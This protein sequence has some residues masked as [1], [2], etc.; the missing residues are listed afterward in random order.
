MK[1]V[2]RSL[3]VLEYI[4]DTQP[5]GVSEIARE[6]DE[7]KSSVQRALDTLA[8]GHWI[9]R[10]ETNPSLW[11]VAVRTAMLGRNFT[12]K[13]D[14][15]TIA[16]SYMET[17][18]QETGETIHLAVPREAS[19]ILIE[20]LESP[21]RLRYVEPLGGAASMF[22]TATGKSVLAHLPETR[23]DELISAHLAAIEET[24]ETRESLLTELAR[25][26]ELG[27][28][29]TSAW[30]SEVYATAAVITG[31][32]G[33]PVAALS[34]SVPTARIT[35][36]IKPLHAELVAAAARSI[37]KRFQGPTNP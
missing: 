19:V 31:E 17:L 9:A 16:L 30:R 1:S 21:H 33:E 37:S 8:K 18:R 10:D 14:I 3:E 32:K 27:Y 15:N 6:L 11:V 7:P 5:V 26:R 29:T 13:L 20:R 4:S 2:G 22:R 36:D 34:I 23:R 28:S 24:G 35:D 25:I 12:G